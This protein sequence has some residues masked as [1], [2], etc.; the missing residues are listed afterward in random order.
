M[1]QEI[2]NIPAF[3]MWKMLNETV[4]VLTKGDCP[5]TSVKKLATIIQS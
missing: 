3:S 5:E 4:P 2:E 1:S